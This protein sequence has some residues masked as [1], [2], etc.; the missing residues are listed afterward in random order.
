[1]VGEG[2]HIFQSFSGAE[3]GLGK[4]KVTRDR[5]HH[6]IRRELGGQR[7]ELAVLGGT[8]P[9]INRGVNGDHFD[10]A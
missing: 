6:H 3:T 1:M 10:P 7:V 5:E 8:H 9:G 2:D 4:R